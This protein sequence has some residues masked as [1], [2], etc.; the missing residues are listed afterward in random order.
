MT[1]VAEPARPHADTPSARVLDATVACLARWG[2]SKTTLDDVARAAG[3]SRATVY[4]LF[5][6]GRDVLVRAALA[7]E[8]DEIERTT[9]ERLLGVDDLGERLAVVVRT[10][11]QAVQQHAALQYVLEHEPEHVLPHLTFGHLDAVLAAA[12]ERLAP[13]LDGDPRSG[14]WVARVV[15]SYAFTPSPHVDLADETDVRRFVVTHL[16]PALERRTSHG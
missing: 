5:P 7:A 13:W 11:V 8:V 14:E 6:G 3:V 9:V 1:L 16:L 15:V 10:L 4:R 2:L 12:G